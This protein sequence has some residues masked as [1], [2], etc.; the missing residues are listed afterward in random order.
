MW[1][2]LKSV[3]NFTGTGV[4]VLQGHGW[5]CSEHII[6]GLLGN[7]GEGSEDGP[8]FF[9]YDLPLGF[10]KVCWG[11][12][13]IVRIK[14]NI[15]IEIEKVYLRYRP[16][17][18]LLPFSKINM[19]FPIIQ[20]SL[21]SLSKSCRWYLKIIITAFVRHLTVYDLYHLLQI[22]QFYFRILMNFFVCSFHLLY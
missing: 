7:R 22:F 5:D 20:S 19:V 21:L 10:R 11:A 12:S 15:L 9:P 1:L 6:D 14:L 3:R 18:I 16:E 2:S 8:F 17:S 4:L 13:L